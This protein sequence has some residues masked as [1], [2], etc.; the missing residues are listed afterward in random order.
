MIRNPDIKPGDAIYALTHNKYGFM[1]RLAQAIRWWKY[2]KQN[3]M[4]IVTKVDKDGQIWVNQMARRCELVRLEDVA[5]NGQLWWVPIPP[6][7]DRKLSVKYA[8]AMLGVQY[9]FL[10]IACIGINLLLLPQIIN[11]D[12]NVGHSLICSELVAKAWEHGGWIC[13]VSSDAITPAEMYKIQ[14]GKGIQIQ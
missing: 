10:T 4:A 7:V 2:H 6:D 13:P 5:P 1:I 11:L 8:N 3:H 9:G 14:D 12:I